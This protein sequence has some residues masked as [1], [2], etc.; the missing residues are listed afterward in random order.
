[1]KVDGVYWR[2]ACVGC[3]PGDVVEVVGVGDVGL[4]VEKR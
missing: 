3:G 2:A 4:V 1:M